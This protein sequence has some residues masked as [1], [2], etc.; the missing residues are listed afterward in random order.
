MPLTV[1]DDYSLCQAIIELGLN[2]KAKLFIMPMQDIC[3]KYGDYRINEPG[4]VK[5]E[6]WTI[7]FEEGEF[8][9]WLSDRLLTL[10]KKYGR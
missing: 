3:F 9:F 10:T 7:R 4:T 1:T 6:N 8:N 2:S 5:N